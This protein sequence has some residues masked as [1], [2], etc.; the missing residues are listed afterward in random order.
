MFPEL[1]SNVL[2]SDF[3]LPEFC[4]HVYIFWLFFAFAKNIIPYPDRFHPHNIR[5]IFPI[6]K[7]QERSSFPHF[8]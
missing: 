6:K 2:C 7:V 3:I 8:L 4:E 5:T 1:L